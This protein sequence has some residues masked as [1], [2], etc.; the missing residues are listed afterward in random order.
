LSG[1]G[2]SGRA[3]LGEQHSRRGASAAQSL[4]VRAVRPLGAMHVSI[5]SSQ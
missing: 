5:L 3:I 4:S 2:R 1:K